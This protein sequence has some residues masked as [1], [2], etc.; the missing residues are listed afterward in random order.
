MLI[1][2]TR[3]LVQ[4]GA[5]S[6]DLVFRSAAFNLSWSSIDSAL[7]GSLQ[8]DSRRFDKGARSNGAWR[9]FGELLHR[10]GMEPQ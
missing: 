3:E 7:L 8:W 2:Q 5:G 9:R 1:A 4:D 6:A 10:I